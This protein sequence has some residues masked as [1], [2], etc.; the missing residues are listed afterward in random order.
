MTK[1]KSGYAVFAAV[2]LTAALPLTAFA[3][4]ASV[5]RVPESQSIDVQAKYED[6]TEKPVVYKVDVEWG[7]MEF[8]YHEAG[9]NKWNPQ[10][11]QYELDTDGSW[12]SQGNTV[13]VKNHSNTAVTASLSF[14]A[15]D[16]LAIEGNF[17]NQTI[18]LDS[19][20]GTAAETPPTGA[21]SLTLS[22]RLDP[23]AEDL[24]TVGQITVAV[25]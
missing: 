7:V 1:Q 14:K 21:A 12:S 4:S 13:T 17:D 6:G 2:L 25:N 11:H 20:V 16:G 19:A 3:G 5:S 23:G 22:G 9:T 8:T 24:R 15:A 10:T 18:P